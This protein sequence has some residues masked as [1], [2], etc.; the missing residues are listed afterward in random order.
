[1]IAGKVTRLS[2]IGGCGGETLLEQTKV[3]TVH[4]YFY[5]NTAGDYLL[6]YTYAYM[7]LK[8]INIIETISVNIHCL[9]VAQTICCEFHSKCNQSQSNDSRLLHSSRACVL[10]HT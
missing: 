9:A 4:V 2:R 8:S 10:T 3:C 5:T 1:M 7:D 6:G